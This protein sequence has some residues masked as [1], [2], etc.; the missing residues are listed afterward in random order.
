[1]EEVKKAGVIKKIISAPKAIT[2]F[3]MVGLLCFFAG[4]YVYKYF[5]EGNAPVITQAEIT[6]QI[7]DIKEL[8]TLEYAYTTVG[9]FENAADFYGTK[10][11]FTT[12]KFVVS[13]DGIIKAGIDFSKIDVDVNGNS[14]IVKLPQATILSHEIDEESLTVYD[15]KNGLFNPITI[16]DY[17]QFTVDQKK[18]ME[19][20][21]INKGILISAKEK[22]GE[23]IKSFLESN[24]DKDT[25][26]VVVE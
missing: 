8:S 1:M 23:V 11:P 20:K 15:E 3:I 16:N 26:K 5:Q 19:E 13:Y 12:K 18:V 17:N 21:A 25:Y 9:S 4:I 7:K 24:F 2:I 10:I 6:E 14:I 22:A